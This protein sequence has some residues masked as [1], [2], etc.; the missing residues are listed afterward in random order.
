VRPLARKFIGQA[1]L[2]VG[3]APAHLRIARQQAA[4]ARRLQSASW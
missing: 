2:H 4:L 3:F 1:K